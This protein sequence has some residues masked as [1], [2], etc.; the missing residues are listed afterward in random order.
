MTASFSAG[1]SRPCTS[2]TA[3]PEHP[4]KRLG[5]GLGRGEVAV[6]GFSDQRADPE[7]LRALGDR[8]A[9]ALDDLADPRLR[10]GAGGHGLPARRLFVQPRDVEVAVDRQLQRA[11]DRRRRH[12]QHVRR[13]RPCLSA[14]CARRRR[15]GAARRSP[16]APAT[17]KATSSWKRAWVPTATAAW[18]EASARQLL[19]ARRAAVA[20]GQQHGLDALRGQ[21]P[22]RWSRSAGGRGSRSGAISADC[23]PARA[24]SAMASMATTVLPAPTS[25]CSSRD[26]RWPDARSARISARLRTCAPVS[27]KGRARSTIFGQRARAD[28][29]RRLRLAVPPCAAPARAGGRRARRRRVGAA[30]ARWARGRRRSA[31]A[32]IAASAARQPGQRWRASQA[33]SCHSGSS[34]ARASASSAS[35]RTVRGVQVAAGRIDRF[36]ARNLVDLLGRQEIVRVGDRASRREMR[37]TLPLTA[38]RAPGGWRRARCSPPPRNQTRNRKPVFVEGADTIGQV[39]AAGREVLVDGDDEG[40]RL[41]V[42]SFGR[43]RPRAVHDAVGAQEQHVAHVRPRQPLQRRRELGS[44]ALQRGRRRE[45]REENL[46]AHALRSI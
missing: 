25:P 39:A 8:G 12:G 23:S 30:P 15:S 16:S 3:G 13:R 42:A 19:G 38:R 14:A 21:R 2:P 4:A 27:R 11:R 32:C 10:R 24:A 40:L 9:Q 37:S 41:A 20:A 34:G 44:D 26:M 1:F 45:Q 43:R 33:G 36:E 31:G 18:P 22:R 35:L 28:A 46:R 5:P 6:L 17:R 29:R 7:G